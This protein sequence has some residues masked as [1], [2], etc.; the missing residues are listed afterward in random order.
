MVKG[1]H[2]EIAEEMYDFDGK[3]H[4]GF[5]IFSRLIGDQIHRLF[6]SYYYKW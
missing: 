2:Q 6:S 5:A 4:I 1:A 3:C